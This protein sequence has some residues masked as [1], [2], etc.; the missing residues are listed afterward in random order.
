MTTNTDNKNNDQTQFIPYVFKYKKPKQ[1]YKDKKLN[2]KNFNYDNECGDVFKYEPN[3]KRDLIF[4]SMYYRS[5][6]DYQRHKP[7]VILTQSINQKSIPNAKR[8]L[9]LYGDPPEIDSLQTMK[10]LGIEVIRAKEDIPNKYKFNAAVHRF[11]SFYEYL[12]EHRDE[13]DRV[14]HSDFRDVI[15]FADGFQ[16]FSY[17][18]IFITSECQITNGR[19][20]CS[21]YKYSDVNYQWMKDTYG[22]EFANKLKKFNERVINVGLMF[23]GTYKMLELLKK[24]NAEFLKHHKMTEEWGFD[25][26]VINYLYHSH[27]LHDV[28]VVQPGQFVSFN[29]FSGLKYDE[30]KKALFIKGTKCSPVVVHKICKD[31][32]LM[33]HP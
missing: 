3:N 19:E 31:I 7:D 32:Q 2:I 4:Y 9:Y 1:Y 11:Q 13:Y 23:G 24:L 16:C 21:S 10:D 26:A 29:I 8:I 6:Y 17:D 15:W 22:L 33:C 27:R 30:K 20:E 28:Q 18:D 25:Q 14:V 5:K 12:Y